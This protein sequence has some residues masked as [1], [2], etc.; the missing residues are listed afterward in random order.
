VRNGFNVIGVADA[1]LFSSFIDML[2]YPTPTFIII[3]LQ[4]S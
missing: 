2:Q 4:A 3:V 1:S